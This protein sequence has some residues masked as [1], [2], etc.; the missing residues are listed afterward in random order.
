MCRKGALSTVAVLIVIVISLQFSAKGQTSAKTA[1]SGAVSSEAEG[2]MEGVLISAKQLGGNI[3]IT[4]VS[5]K[6]GRYSFT[7]NQLPAG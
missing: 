2:P 3:T 5:D 6:Q 7:P 1:L 4:V